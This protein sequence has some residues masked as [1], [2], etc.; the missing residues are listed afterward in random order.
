MK[1]MEKILSMKRELQNRGIDYI[2]FDT[3]PGL[4]YSSLN[5]IVASDLVFIVVKLDVSDFDGT[6]GML[7]GIHSALEKKTWL[8][9]NQVPVYNDLEILIF[10]GFGLGQGSYKLTEY[11][12]SGHN[13]F[14]I[15]F[16]SIGN[17]LRQGLSSDILFGKQPHQFLRQHHRLVHVE[18]L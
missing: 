9:V 16:F 6:I 15:Q 14:S 10:I 4:H 11:I 7:K 1:A 5:A 12:N 8:I 18:Y 17:S 13:T 2:C 3:S